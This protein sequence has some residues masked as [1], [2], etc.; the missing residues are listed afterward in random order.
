MGEFASGIYSTAALPREHGKRMEWLDRFQSKFG[1]WYQS[2]FGVEEDSEL[3]PRDVLRKIVDAM[4][5]FRSEGL[6]GRV[7]VPNK[8]V[9]ELAV[10]NADERA[11]MLSFL[12][13]QE[14]SSVL[15]RYIAHKNYLTRGPL[16]FIIEEIDALPGEDKLYVRALFDKSA[17]P[18]FPAAPQNPAPPN[19]AIPD[20]AAVLDN[21]THL[22][23]GGGVDEDERIVDEP[24]VH[25]RA[26]AHDWLEDATVHAAPTAWAALLVESVDGQRSLIS[27]NKA[28]FTV[29]RSRHS[30]NDL[31]LAE[32]GQVSKRH[33][34][35]ERENDGHATLYDLAST[36]GTFVNQQIVPV[37]ITLGSGDV[38]LIGRTRIEFQLQQQPS[39]PARPAVSQQLAGAGTSPVL[40]APAGGDPTAQVARL[41]RVSD[42]STHL[43]GSEALIGR[44]MTCDITL[45]ETAVSTQQARIQKSE[46]STADAPR[47]TVQDLSGR[48]STLVNGRPMRIAERFPLHSGDK[49]TLGGVGFT[50]TL[51]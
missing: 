22:R 28:V 18:E 38:I 48:G 15:E 45:T 31:V 41:T 16:D 33:A 20:L 2:H 21:R 7:Y 37:N 10:M 24:T 42:G 29:G 3:T 26:Q 11:Y 49:I 19:P 17:K 14:L 23:Y 40:S 47:Y 46:D 30:N 36:N 32:D 13:E 4:E 35:I 39:T 27:I 8:Y 9:L 34:R 5:S 25:A 51:E 12:D 50:F 43:L 44:S 6:D 1:S